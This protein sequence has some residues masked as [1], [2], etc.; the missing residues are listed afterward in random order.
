MMA[1]EVPER[2]EVV[3]FNH[4]PSPMVMVGFGDISDK[5][6]V[7]INH[8]YEAE[9]YSLESTDSRDEID[10]IERVKKFYDDAF[11]RYPNGG[12]LLQR[13]SPMVQMVNTWGGR[14]IVIARARFSIIPTEC[15]V[16]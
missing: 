2:F 12:K 1:I 15:P 6:A 14:K 8:D 13:L 4:N 11:K 7:E 5:K 3:S 16:T 9:H 10:G